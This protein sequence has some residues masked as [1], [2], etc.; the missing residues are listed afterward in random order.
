MKNALLYPIQHLK[1]VLN[2]RLT[3]RNVSIVVEIHE[4]RVDLG[5]AFRC[6]LVDSPTRKCIKQNGTMC[7]LNKNN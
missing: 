7:L 3:H 6:T 4:L 2:L 1:P 5:S